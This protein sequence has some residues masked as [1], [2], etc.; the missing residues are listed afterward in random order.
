MKIFNY[1]SIRIYKNLA[2]TLL[3]VA[4]IFG[5]TI[6]AGTMV[7]NSA[8]VFPNSNVTPL[9]QASG[10]WKKTSFFI[11]YTLKP[12]DIER[13]VDN[14]LEKYPGADVLLDYGFDTKI[15]AFMGFYFLTMNVYG[16][17]AKMEVGLQDID[18]SDN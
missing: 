14:A 9:G 3:F 1:K 18:Q 8:Y 13:L 7:T 2:F 16:T 12:A 17:A 10:E 11:P 6:K 15:T 5:C 4:T